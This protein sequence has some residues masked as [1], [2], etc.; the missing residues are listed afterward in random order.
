MFFLFSCAV[1]RQVIG[2]FDEFLFF[3]PLPGLFID[4][5]RTLIF[6][7]DHLHSKPGLIVVILSDEISKSKTVFILNGILF[8][9]VAPPAFT[10]FMADYQQVFEKLQLRYN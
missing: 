10:P 2:R 5:S 3:P 1:A 8:E 7:L 4:V 9:K 6:V